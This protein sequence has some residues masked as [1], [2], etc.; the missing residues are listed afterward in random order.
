MK[1]NHTFSRS[2]ALLVAAA[3]LLLAGCTTYTTPG[4]G[5]AVVVSPRPAYY[6]PAPVVYGSSGVYRGAYVAGGPNVAYGRTAAGG[7]AYRVGDSG[8]AYSA[9]GGS[10]QWN[11]GS[12]SASGA[13]GGLWSLAA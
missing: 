2:S 1:T 8:R 12:G 13:R 4:Y 6:G 3:V 11:N 7:T 5:G 9:R 10:A